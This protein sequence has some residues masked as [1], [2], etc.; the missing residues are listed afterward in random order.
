M[1]EG[2]ILHIV[3]AIVTE[4]FLKFTYTKGND[5]ITPRMGFSGLKE[6]DCW[7]LCVM[8]WIES[9]NNG[10]A[11]PVF[12]ENTDRNVLKYVNFDILKKYALDF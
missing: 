11:P 8:R 2:W 12:L 3:C 6:G 9:Y 7:C 5:L 4:D 1:E 10:V